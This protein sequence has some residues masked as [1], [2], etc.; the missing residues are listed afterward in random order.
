MDAADQPRGRG[1]PRHR[2]RRGAAA[3]RA[4][5][6]LLGRRRR[7]AAYAARARGRE[8]EVGSPRSAARPGRRCATPAVR[9]TSTGLRRATPSRC[10]PPTTSPPRTAP[11][12]AHRARLRRGRQGGHRRGRHRGGHAGR[13]RRP[14]HCTGRRL[15]GP[16]TVFDANLQIIHD[17]KAGT[18]RRRT[19]APCCCA[20]RPTTHPY[21]HCWRCRKP[22]IYKAVSSLVRRGDRVPRPDGASSTSRSPGCPSTSRTASSASGWRT[23]ATG[24]SPAT[25][26]GAAP[27]PVWKSDDPAY[28]RIDVYGSLDELERDFGG[29]DRTATDL[30]RPYVDELTRPNPDDPTGQVDDAPGPRR[31][32]RAGSTRARCRSPRCTTRSRTRDWFDAPLP[33]RL[34]RRVHRPDPRLVLHAARA[35]DA[36]CS[37]GRRSGPASATASCSATT[38]RRCRKSLRNYPDVSEVFDRDGADAMRWFLMSSPILR[39]GNLVVTEQGIREGVRQVLM[40][41]WNTWYFFAL[42]ANATDTGDVAHRLDDTCWT[43]TC[44]PRLARA[45]STVDRRD[46][47]S[48]TSPAPATRC[49]TS[50]TC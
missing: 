27:I 31:A 8:P 1:R 2:L 35:G 42:Y 33:R 12:R 45:A 4:A 37:T 48:T 7:L 20:T 18:V 39:G 17:L 49:A 22:L 3:G 50:S 26:S 15:R 34:H 30:H 46:W 14:V 25:G 43:A 23:P 24:R 16:C 32:R 38:A 9:P 28:P 44:W 5:A 11:A 41:L 19:T 40:P 36:R 47:T 29:P 10:W 6:T 21:P 13:Q